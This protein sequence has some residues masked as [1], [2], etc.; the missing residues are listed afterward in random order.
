MRWCYNEGIAVL[1]SFAL[2]HQS[3]AAIIARRQMVRL[4]SP[5][6][7]RR[8]RL[9]G[10][11]LLR[12]R[13][14]CDLREQALNDRFNAKEALLSHP[15]RLRHVRDN[16]IFRSGQ[17]DIL[18]GGCYH[19]RIHAG[20]A[21]RLSRPRNPSHHP[22]APRKPRR[23]TSSARGDA[24]CL[25]PAS[26][27]H[28]SHERE[29]LPAGSAA[30]RPSPRIGCRRPH[31]VDGGRPRCGCL[32]ARTGLPDTG[33]RVAAAEAYVHPGYD[34]YHLDNDLAL[35]RLSVPV[36]QTPISCSVPSPGPTNMTTCV[37]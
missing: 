14:G 3:I 35:L 25:A 15:V 23:R 30:A 11:E 2:A 37:R 29:H 9:S 19:R 12:R 7:A 10:K 8:S 4:R 26:F 28:Q 31:R 21:Q 6:S 22:P 34:P 5:H 32:S 1:E 27:L 36:T 17:I 16:Q 20:W 24:W 13:T 33:T 18:R